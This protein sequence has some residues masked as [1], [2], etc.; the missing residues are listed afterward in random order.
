MDESRDRSLAAQI[1]EMAGQ[2]VVEEAAED[3]RLTELHRR[4]RLTLE[5]IGK[6]MVNR[7]DRVSIEFG[8]HSFSGVVVSGGADYVS[9]NGPGQAAEIKLSEARWSVLPHD[10]R[11]SETTPSALETFTAVLHQ[12]SADKRN[13]RL[14]LPGGD[15]VIGTVVVVATDHVEMSDVDGRQLVVPMNLILGLVRS[16]DS[17]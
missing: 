6:E 10:G 7:G 4:R 13:V 9:I 5:D 2:D 11:A 15:M 12:Y 16:S 1:R 17:Q 8:G 3:E 14:A